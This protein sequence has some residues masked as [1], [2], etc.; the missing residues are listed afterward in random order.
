MNNTPIFRDESWRENR[1]NI[2]VGI[3]WM[4]IVN[5]KLG[6]T[7]DQNIGDTKD[8]EIG[9]YNGRDIKVKIQRMKIVNGI[10]NG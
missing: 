6:D 2:K 8:M 4:Q 9:R 5:E 7:T 3:Q 1:Q 10:Y